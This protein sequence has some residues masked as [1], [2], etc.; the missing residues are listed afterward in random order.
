MVAATSIIAPPSI[1]Q[2]YPSKP[3]RFIVPFPPGGGTDIVARLFGRKLV[4]NIGQQ[5]IIDNRGGANAII[6]TDLAAKAAPDGYT[7][8][9]VLPASVAVN[10][11][12]YRNLPYDPARD[13]AP[14]IQLNS[15]PQL[16]AAHPSLPANSVRD[17]IQLAKSKPGQ[18]TFASSGTGGSSHLAME[19]LKIMAK[20]DMVHVPYKGGG[21]AMNDLLGGQV[22]LY[23]GTVIGSLPFVKAG[24]LK[25]LGLTSPRRS[26]ALPGVPTIAET[27]PGYEANTWQGIVVPKATPAP[28]IARLNREFARILEQPDV[29]ERFAADATE[30]IGGTP[31]EFDAVIKADAAKYAKLLKEAGIKPELP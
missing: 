23:T 13:F 27:V 5:I 3:V 11:S 24:K 21:P 17:L 18:I 9:L 25:A 19:L 31:A 26:A 2:T 8:L 15:I 4:E 29:R 12:L 22:Q 30:P 20:V 1:A 10:P 28:I 16:L 14:V 7:I 6:G